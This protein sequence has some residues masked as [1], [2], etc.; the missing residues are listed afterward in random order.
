MVSTA[1]DLIQAWTTMWNSYDLDEVE[2]LF[3]GDDRLTYLSSEKQGVIAGY[4]AI[5]QHH[6]GFGFVP[7]GK[8]TGNRLWLEDLVYSDLGGVTVVA[9]VWLFKRHGSAAVQRGPVTFVCLVN[10]GGIGY[11]LAH[12]NF[13]NY[14]ADAR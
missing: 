5:V 13:G 1:E 4:E 11:R 14:P 2:R 8:D 12:L 10:Q 7:G 6:R 9:G 3:V